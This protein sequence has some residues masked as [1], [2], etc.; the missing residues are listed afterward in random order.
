MSTLSLS[1]QSPETSKVWAIL[2]DV[3][4]QKELTTHLL[5]VEHFSSSHF[6]FLFQRKEKKND[7]NAGFDWNDHDKI[8]TELSLVHEPSF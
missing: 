1:I 2:L 6:L 8:M 5:N 3:S 4:D 7:S